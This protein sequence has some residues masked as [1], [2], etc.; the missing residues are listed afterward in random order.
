MYRL[1]IRD[2]GFYDSDTLATVAEK[3]KNLKRDL[4]IGIIDSLVGCVIV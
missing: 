1:A 3:A 2:F 4:S